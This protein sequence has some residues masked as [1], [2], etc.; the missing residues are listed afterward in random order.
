MSRG[1][2]EMRR[3]RSAAKQMS[4]DYAEIRRDN[5]RDESLH[6][7]PPT[8]TFSQRG[9]HRHTKFRLLA[10]PVR[11]FSEAPQWQNLELRVNSQSMQR[12]SMEM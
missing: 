8:D 12:G 4:G 5:R 9:S 10:K 2:D 7:N 6:M 3:A 1:P 11:R